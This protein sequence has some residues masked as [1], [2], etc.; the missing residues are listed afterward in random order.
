MTG[1]QKEVYD[2][3]DQIQSRSSI[4]SFAAERA[5]QKVRLDEFLEQLVSFQLMLQEGNQYL[6]LAV[7]TERCRKANRVDRALI[8][9]V[10]EC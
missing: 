2:F 9:E 10:V 7:D 5:G 6:S 3:C 1:L 8:R 4:E